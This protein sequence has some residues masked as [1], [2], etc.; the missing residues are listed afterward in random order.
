[1]YWFLTVLG[2]MITVAVRGRGRGFSAR[3]AAGAM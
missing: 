3:D 2:A 1:M